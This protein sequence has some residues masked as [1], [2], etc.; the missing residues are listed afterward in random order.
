MPRNNLIAIKQLH[1]K[2]ANTEIKENTIE[3]RL[4]INANFVVFFYIVQYNFFYCVLYIN[5]GSYKIRLRLVFSYC[6]I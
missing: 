3:L 1:R 2:T 5:I 6:T 4:L